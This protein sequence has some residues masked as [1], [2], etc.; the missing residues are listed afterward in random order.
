MHRFAGTRTRC[1]ETIR[2]APGNNVHL[3]APGRPA[4]RGVD[5]GVHAKFRN[6]F[7]WY[8]QPSFGLLRLLLNAAGVDAVEC[9]VVIVARPAVE[10][11]V[12]LGTS[13]GVD[14]SR[15][16]HH[17]SRKRA[18]VE[19]NLTD[20]RRIDDGSNFR[21]AAIDVFQRG[22]H[23]HFCGNAADLEVRVNRAL[24]AGGKNHAVNRD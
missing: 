23:L 9:E 1:R 4:L 6:G 19:R 5:G 14:R 17:E 8:L 18:P 15:G 2:S 22:A 11:D 12:A 16:Q 10:P 7:Q 21:R 20:L 13:T 3:P 24:L